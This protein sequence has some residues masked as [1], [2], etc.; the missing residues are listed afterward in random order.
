[1]ARI[2]PFINMRTGERW[3]KDEIK[4]ICQT[5]TYLRTL[6]NS[7]WPSYSEKKGMSPRPIGCI[8][9]Q[10]QIH[11]RL[12]EEKKRTLSIEYMNI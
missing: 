7:P 5:G 3:V 1:L 12:D 4:L 8:S 10:F 6:S 9:I 2:R 11:H